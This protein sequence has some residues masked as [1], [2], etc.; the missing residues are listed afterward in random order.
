Q[1]AQDRDRA[2]ELL[3]ERAH[4]LDSLRVGR[5][6]AMAQID[7]ERVRAR[8]EQAAK[9]VR[10]AARGA[11]RG[12]DLGLAAARF[13]LCHADRPMAERHDKTR[14]QGWQ[15][16][17]IRSISSPTPWPLP[18][19]AASCGTSGIAAT[20][21]TSTLWASRASAAIASPTGSARPAMKAT[22]QPR[23]R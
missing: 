20:R 12:E 7:A 18:R 6:I 4:G 16:P 15:P 9:H 11:E 10:I 8:A 13:E 1:V 14:R 5:V 17:P 23:A 19:S 2:E 21:R 22:R 3:L